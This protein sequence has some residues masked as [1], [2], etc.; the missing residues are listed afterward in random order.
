MLTIFHAGANRRH[1]NF[2][3]HICLILRARSSAFF[4]RL[5]VGCRV[6]CSLIMISVVW[7]PSLAV[8]KI[9]SLFGVHLTY[10]SLLFAMGGAAPAVWQYAVY[11]SLLGSSP[12]RPNV[13]HRFRSCLGYSCD[14][15]VVHVSSVFFAVLGD[16]VIGCDLVVTLADCQP[17]DKSDGNQRSLQGPISDWFGETSLLCGGPHGQLN[18]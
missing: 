12:C 1:S 2:V 5:S 18:H 10:C 6:S 15:D 14:R 17:Q 8:P 4:S 11:V 7:S 16:V 9:I 3:L 13:R